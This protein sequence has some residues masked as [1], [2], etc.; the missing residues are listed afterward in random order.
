VA[1][2]ARD[3][4]AHALFPTVLGVALVWLRAQGFGIGLRGPALPGIAV[5]F[6]QAAAGQPCF[7]WG[8]GSRA[9]P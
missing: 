6:P 9:S 7:G 5:L 4:R 8:P 2:A 3:W 1:L